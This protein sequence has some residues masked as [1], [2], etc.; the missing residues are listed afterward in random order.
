[1]PL[2][3]RLTGCSRGSIL[4]FHRQR[5]LGAGRHEQPARPSAES[6]LRRGR[7]KGVNSYFWQKGTNIFSFSLKSCS[8][9]MFRQPRF[10][11]ISF[12]CRAL[13][14]FT[15]IREL[16]HKVLF[17]LTQYFGAPKRVHDYLLKVMAIIPIQLRI[18]PLE[19]R[20]RWMRMLGH[21]RR[22]AA[23]AADTSNAPCGPGN[24]TEE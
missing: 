24:M 3:R 13:A 9:Q 7:P 16:A 21:H 17:S 12:C 15:E 4:G 11:N 22:R 6:S 5:F 1:M 20:L 23:A 8:A 2:T 19:L 14:N 18:L 10:W